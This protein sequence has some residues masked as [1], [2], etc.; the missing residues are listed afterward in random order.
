MG[1]ERVAHRGRQRRGSDDRELEARDVGVHRD[2][3]ERGVDGGNRGHRGDPVAL[4]EP[5]EVPVQGA[6]AIAERSGPDDVQALEQRPED[7]HQQRVR[8]EQRQGGEHGAAGPE[9]IEAGDHPRVGDL[10]GVGASG[11]LRGAGRPAGVQVARDVGRRRRRARK[12]RGVGAGHPL[13]E[14]GD[15]R[16]AERRQ[17]R[18]RSLRRGRA[19]GEERLRPRRLRDVAGVLPDDRV[20][21]RPGGDDDARAREADELGGV[22][23]RERRVDRAKIPTAS[24]ASSSGTSSAQLTETTATASPRSTPRSASTFAARWTSA[25]SSANVR[26]AGACQRSASGSTDAAV[27]SGHS[28]AARVTSS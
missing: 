6:V 26:R 28:S 5:P 2:L 22:L 12:R 19:Q 16:R 13:R 10:V 7:G 15:L 23:G 9:Q 14:I 11:E 18:R 21:L 17:R 1:L 25:A 24:A 8:V 27:R 4:D 20:Q 3:R